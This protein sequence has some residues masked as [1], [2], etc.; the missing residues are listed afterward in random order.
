MIRQTDA[1]LRM[2]QSDVE[3]KLSLQTIAGIRNGPMK[4]WWAAAK[5]QFNPEFVERVESY[6]QAINTTR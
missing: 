4:V 3:R 1:N 6:A 2:P 5:A